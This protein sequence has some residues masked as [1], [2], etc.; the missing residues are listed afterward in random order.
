MEKELRENLFGDVA[1]MSLGAT[2]RT[3]IATAEKIFRDHRA[4]AAFDFTP[5]VSSLAKALEVT[6]NE[7]L[8]EVSAK[9]PP[10]AQRV[11]IEDR[12][13]VV[14]RGRPLMLGEFA[15]VVAEERTLNRALAQRLE[16]GGW[17]TGSLPVIVK[18]LLKVRNPG[19]H[20]Q[21][22]DRETATL[23]RNQL[24]G[25][26]Y[27]GVFQQLARVRPLARA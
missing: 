14:G 10:G 27:P 22:I 8:T 13:I 2:T 6:C 26:G 17:F 16:N 9:L 19:V 18:E 21:R 11:K 7:I 4:D 5:V 3:F 12:E 24:V 23:M 20:E 25:I 15:R 1:W